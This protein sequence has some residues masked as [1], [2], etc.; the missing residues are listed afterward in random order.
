MSEASTSPKHKPK[1][2]KHRSSK[3]TSNTTKSE[4]R[5]IVYLTS[6]FRLRCYPAVPFGAIANVLLMTFPEKIVKFSQKVVLGE[7]KSELEESVRLNGVV[8]IRGWLAEYG[9][10]S[11]VL[12]NIDM[13]GF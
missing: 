4:K 3:T 7:L 6:I 11:E 5:S 8:G 10:F 13:L 12:V 1:E 2:R 9:E